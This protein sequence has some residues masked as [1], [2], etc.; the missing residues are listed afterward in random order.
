MAK[1]FGVVRVDPPGGVDG[2]KSGAVRQWI[3]GKSKIQVELTDGRVLTGIFSCFD[4]QRNII[5]QEAYEERKIMKLDSSSAGPKNES[6]LQTES[7]AADK[8]SQTNGTPE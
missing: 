2:Q 3:N 8:E 5:L 6:G 4:A 1:R 7:I